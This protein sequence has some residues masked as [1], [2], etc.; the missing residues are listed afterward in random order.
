MM[1]LSEIRSLTISEAVFKTVAF[2]DVFDFCLTPEELADRLLGY[3]ASLTEIREYLLNPV[4]VAVQDG[5]VFLAGRD[6]LVSMRKNGE[7][8]HDLL[9]RKV[10][11]F[12]WLFRWV[13]FLEGVYLCNRLTMAQ[14][15]AGSDIDIFVVARPGRLFIVRTFMTALFHL[16][17]LR[18]H[19]TRV[20]GRFCLSFFVD[21]SGVSLEGHL[22][23]PCDPYFAYWTLLLQP[24]YGGVD[25]LAQN[26]WL[27]DYFSERVLRKLDSDI[28]EKKDT[29]GYLGD[30][31]ESWLSRWQLARAHRTL[32]SLGNPSGV[33]L[34]RHCLK[35]HD[36][37]MRQEYVENWKSKIS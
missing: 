1:F 8:H 21:Q 20:A 15:R 6:D 18:R 2:F 9:L 11:R 29:R 31:L 33:I 30:L 35:F 27:R 12:Q 7:A 32:R 4:G 36:R 5:Y 14:A 37:D 13:P 17:G 16:L 23:Q 24:L 34:T 22:R 3:D 26:G 28:P 10:H 19:G 25:I